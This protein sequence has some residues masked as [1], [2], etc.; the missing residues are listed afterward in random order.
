M[1]QLDYLFLAIGL[2]VA[3]LIVFFVSFILYRKLP[4][5]KG[6]EDIKISEENCGRCLKKDQCQIKKEG[7]K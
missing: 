1:S 7:N 6:C 5:P 2:L 4:A 3:L